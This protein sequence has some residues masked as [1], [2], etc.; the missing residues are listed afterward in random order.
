M[1]VDIEKAR[2][3]LRWALLSLSRLAW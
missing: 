1:W 3:G 2:I